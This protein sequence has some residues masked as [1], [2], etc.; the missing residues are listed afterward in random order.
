MF[1]LA[2]YSH[3]AEFSNLPHET[4][5]SSDEITKDVK[6]LTFGLKDVP[7]HPQNEVK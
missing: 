4:I 3:N 1:L 7:L 6:S 5:A 2:V